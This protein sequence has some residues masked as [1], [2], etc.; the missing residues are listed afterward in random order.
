[1]KNVMMGVYED[2]E[3]VNEVVVDLDDVECVKKVLMDEFD[4]GSDVEVVIEYE[5]DEVYIGVSEVEYL[6]CKVG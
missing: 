4:C 2:G 6:W 1:M 3:K 5:G